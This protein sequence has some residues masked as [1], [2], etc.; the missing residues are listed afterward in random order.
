MAGGDYI[1][2]RFMGGNNY[3]PF[4][5]TDAGSVFV[6]ESVHAEGAEEKVREWHEQGLPVP[7]WAMERYKRGD[8]PGSH[9]SNCPYTPENGYGEIA[10]NLA[11]HWDKGIK[12]QGATGGPR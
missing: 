8:L 1:F 12:P 10:V 11:V 3:M 5:L 6:F 4:L 7:G 9:W 2:R